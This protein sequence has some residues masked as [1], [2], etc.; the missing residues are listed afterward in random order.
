MHAC[1]FRFHGQQL[2]IRWA[3]L[4]LFYQYP[5]ILLQNIVFHFS[6]CT[7]T[8]TD[9]VVIAKM[10][11]TPCI[12]AILLVEIGSFS[13]NAVPTSYIRSHFGSNG[14]RNM[15]QKLAKREKD[16]LYS[17]TCFVLLAGLENLM[18][19]NLLRPTGRTQSPAGRTLDVLSLTF[20][21]E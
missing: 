5:N 20:N 4:K 10:L 12:A 9:I 6:Y 15:N 14:R 17:V 8:I 18:E 19:P 2:N 7:Q 13:A 21:F 3:R 11:T 16:A 1:K